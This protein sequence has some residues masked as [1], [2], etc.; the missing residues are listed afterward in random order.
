MIIVYVGTVRQGKTLGAVIELKKFYDNGY[1][2]YSNTWLSFPYK[3]LTLEYLF[4]IV[5]KELNLPD[6]CVFFIDEIHIWLDSRVGV[7]K[8]NRIV[9]YFLLQTGKLGIDTDF[10]LILLATTQFTHLI[11]K[12]LKDLIDILAE[13]EKI[14][15]RGKKFFK[16]ER[17]YFRGKK[18]FKRIIGFEGLKKYYDLYDTRKKITY[19]KTRYDEDN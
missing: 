14:T 6:R 11:D 10:G 13:C 19:K 9:S 15:Y 7:S 2:I 5:E 1:I 16:Q 18:T 17:T 3:V 8:R 12:R 4:D